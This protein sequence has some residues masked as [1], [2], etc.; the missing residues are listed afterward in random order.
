MKTLTMMIYKK[1]TTKT[2]C[3]D[4]S[5][6]GINTYA[7]IFLYLS[8]FFVCFLQLSA[9]ET[10]SN[11]VVMPDEYHGLLSHDTTTAI[12]KQ[13]IQRIN[14]NTLF[15]ILSRQGELYGMSLG[16]NGHNNNF[17]AY[18][19][20]DNNITYSYNGIPLTNLYSG[21]YNIQ[22]FSPEFFERIEVFKGSDAVIL[23]PTQSQVYT[24]IQEIIYNTKTPFTRMWYS[25]Q[26][27]SFISVDGVFSQN[28]A[29]DWNF[30][31]GFKKMSDNLDFENMADDSWN[32]RALLRYNIDSSSSLSLVNNFT[33]NKII[34]NGGNNPEQS[35]DIYSSINSVPYFSKIQLRKYR[36]DLNLTY[37]NQFGLFRLTNSLYFTSNVNERKLPK[38]SEDDT[39]GN[40]DNTEI[41]IGNRVNLD[42]N[43]KSIDFKV[44]SNVNSFTSNGTNYFNEY[45]GLL[46]NLYSRMELQIFDNSR[47]SGG[48]NYGTLAGNSFLGAGAKLKVDLGNSLVYFDY[49]YSSKNG[50][51]TSNNL[52]NEKTNLIIFG[53]DIDN[54]IKLEAYY[55]NSKDPIY[56][57]LKNEY[58]T[59]QI[60]IGDYQAYGGFITYNA[61]LMTDIFDESDNLSLFAQARFN[62][63]NG[64]DDLKD[65]Y[66]P[67]TLNSGF[68]YK[69]MVN[70]SELNLGLKAGLLGEKSAPRF[71]PI[72]NSY[73]LSNTSVGMQTT[74]L[75]V[76][77]IAKLGNA[78]VKIEWSNILDANYYIA[79]YFPERGRTIKL[80]VAW[81]F[82]D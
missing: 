77:A 75:G 16:I 8:V 81:S 15:D 61:T 12:T 45:S 69:F 27:G 44:G 9:K 47:F 73:I 41:Q 72:S 55:R 29:K 6:K 38:F 71:I 56:Y 48:V 24:N 26:G 17:F 64:N 52:K 54:N 34:T 36:H 18:G 35:T 79:S 62:L 5:A 22:D 46:W 23:S 80:S 25:Q 58:I 51:V 63:I 28:F 14:Y 40:V 49:S 32:I 57:K 21:S 43:Y 4:M 19:S 50:L 39:L 66:P 68:N 33:N 30:T 13:N 7:G 10:D 74:G 67:F 82:F 78:F 76:Y 31:F 3:F 11:R 37:T 53:L 70:Q 60:N 59:E 42:F 20:L 65:Y 2:L 1:L